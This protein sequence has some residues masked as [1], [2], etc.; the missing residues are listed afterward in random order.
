MKQPSLKG[1]K[2]Y[3]LINVIP[4]WLPLLLILSSSTM[5]GQTASLEAT[6]SLEQVSG[7]MVPYQNGFAL[8]S[9]E[10]QNRKILDL[11]G[12]WKKQ[13]FAA[14]DNVTLAKR[15]SAGYQNLINEAAGRN[16]SS[17]DDSGWETKVPSGS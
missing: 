12:D 4:S 2:G 1:V 11:R 15:D 9:F 17:F 3:F 14:S 5:Y 16:S 8:P 13:R 7:V 10:K 6:L